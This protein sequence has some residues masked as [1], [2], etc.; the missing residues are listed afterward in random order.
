MLY[1]KLTPLEYL[2]LVAGLW[3]VAAARRAQAAELIDILDL[4]PH[5]SFNA[6]RAFRA[7]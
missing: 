7:A 3:G 6:A 2:E 4:G 5:R 1:D